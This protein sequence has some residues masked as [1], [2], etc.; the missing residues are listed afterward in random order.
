MEL[1]LDKVPLRIE[2]LFL[3]AVLGVLALLVLAVHAAAQRTKQHEVGLW[4]VRVAAGAAIWL[5]STGLLA[6]EG[7]LL[8]FSFPPKMFFLL[9]V[10]VT[11][12]CS[13]AFSR[14]GSVL[15]AGIGP[16]GLVAFQFFRLPVE[17]FLHGMYE[18]GQV[19]VQMSYAGLN[20]DIF[21][22][23]T[24]PAMAWLLWRGK[25]G[26]VGLWGWNLFGLLLLVN[27]VTVAIFSM[28]TEFRVFMNEPA[29]LFVAYV[30]YVW[31]PAVLI[32]AALL[33]HL[34]VFRWLWADRRGEQV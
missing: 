19:P 32:P 31:L 34:L 4:T 21:T 15:V 26:R 1:A 2:L 28:P 33:G 13:V 8:D 11:L 7:V 30:P 10:S 14:V 18:A 16:V 5:A 3:A 17:I 23:L 6:N 22:G 12:A 20:F 24:A 9:L 27:I 29:N 25:L